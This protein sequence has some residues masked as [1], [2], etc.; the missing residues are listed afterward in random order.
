MSSKQGKRRKFL[1]LY[2]N[3]EVLA[4]D[5]DDYIDAWHAKS[6]GESIYDFL[7]FSKEEYSLWLR[8]PNTLPYIAVARHEN[9]PL[10]DVIASQLNNM[11]M[12]ARSSD[13]FKITRLRA[14]LEQ[15]KKI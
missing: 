9:K 10:N 15:H 8:D 1:D 3:G 7:G 12:A 6:E 11:A 5:I 13:V 14:W 4:E 2:L